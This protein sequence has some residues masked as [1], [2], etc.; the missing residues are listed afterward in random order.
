MANQ[1]NEGRDLSFLNQPFINQMV[2]HP[3]KAP[4]IT[5][6]LEN[7]SFLCF[8][9]EKEIKV[10]GFLHKVKNPKAPT[11]L[12]FHGNGEIAEDYHEL[13]PE[14]LK[15]GINFCVVDYRGY[16]Q[17]NGEPS[18]P[19]MIQDSHNIFSQFK[20][21]LKQLGIEGSI[22]IM[23][24][25]LG[26]ASAI[27]LAGTYQNEISG[28][29]I[30]SGFTDTYGLLQRLGI[31]RKFLPEDKEADISPLPLMETIVIPTLIIHGE[32]DFIIPT[33]NGYALYESCSSDKKELVVIPNAGH[34][35][36]LYLGFDR[37]MKAIESFF[38]EQV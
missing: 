19:N 31:P 33:N 38:Q 1:M 25:S 34:N 21:Y 7:R 15:R 9:V 29:I 10:C 3:R 17:S 8:D 37:Y 2:F 4:E 5:D 11:I 30:E 14:Y 36:L 24:R 18:L 35:D 22:S 16:G 28:L 6:D 12:F 13:A 26:S 27:E 20:D 32:S 23:G